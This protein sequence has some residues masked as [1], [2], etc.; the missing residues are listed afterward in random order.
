M[1]L[2]MIRGYRIYSD[3]WNTVIDEELP[4]VKESGN[5]AV[6][7]AVG[8]MKFSTVG[9]RYRYRASTDSIASY[10]CVGKNFRRFLISHTLHM[11]ET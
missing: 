7:F 8:V 9:Y 10:T 5:L 3:I 2:A 4:C 11:F 1:I 6:P